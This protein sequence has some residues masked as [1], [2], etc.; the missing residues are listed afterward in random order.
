MEQILK[1]KNPGQLRSALMSARQAQEIWRIAVGLEKQPASDKITD[2]HIAAVNGAK[3]IC[4]EGHSI[5]PQT[6][7]ESET[8]KSDT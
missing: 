7:S 1:A 3:A 2:E 5:F 4:E 8:T 6:E